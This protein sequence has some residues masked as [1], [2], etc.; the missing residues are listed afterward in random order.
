M[1]IVPP[2]NTAPCIAMMIPIIAFMEKATNRKIVTRF[3][4]SQSESLMTTVVIMRHHL[5]R[6]LGLEEEEYLEES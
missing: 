2:S 5:N 6:A 4:V 1:A 3:S